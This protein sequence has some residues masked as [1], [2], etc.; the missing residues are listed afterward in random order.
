M[1]KKRIW[2]VVGGLLVFDALTGIPGF[3]A[4]V[5]QTRTFYPSDYSESGPHITTTVCRGV[6]FI[7]KSCEARIE[8]WSMSPGS[9]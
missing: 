8:M 7:W 9:E 5:T 1:K 4:I 3:P 2:L 6:P